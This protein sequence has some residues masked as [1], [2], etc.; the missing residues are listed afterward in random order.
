VRPS[1]G[2][3]T[4]SAFLP[5]E[6]IVL[7]GERWAGIEDGVL[8]A[9]SFR[10]PVAHGLAPRVVDDSK[11]SKAM[12]FCSD[13]LGEGTQHGSPQDDGQKYSYSENGRY[14]DLRLHAGSP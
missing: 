6:S 7:P 10:V 3:K 4:A 9:V 14:D 13:T 1:H 8:Q 5:F 11:L 12:R 2:L